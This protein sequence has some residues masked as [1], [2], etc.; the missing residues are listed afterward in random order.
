MYANIYGD[1]IKGSKLSY[2]PAIVQKG[3]KLHRAIDF[4]IDNHKKVLSL[5]N[6][7]STDLPKI[8]GIAIDLYFDHLLAIQWSE[9]KP[10]PLEN[11]TKAFHNHEFDTNNFEN[12]HFLF[13]IEKMKSDNW[14]ANYQFSHGL[15]FAC[16]GLSQRISFSNQLYNAPEIFTTFRS[17]IK[18]TFDDFMTDAIPFFKQY[19]L[20]LID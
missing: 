5:K 15:D 13:L 11:F 3:V 17:E 12:K 10:E 14:L 8:S 20:E 4:Y 9:F 16:K 7:L 18:A 1:F 19:H 2:Y 6:K